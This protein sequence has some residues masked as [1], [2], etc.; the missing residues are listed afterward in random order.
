[1]FFYITIIK[2]QQTSR[3]KTIIKLIQ[4]ICVVP[5]VGRSG[6]HTAGSSHW[7]E[8]ALHTPTHRSLSK[9][10]SFTSVYLLDDTHI[11]MHECMTACLPKETIDAICGQTLSSFY[12]CTNVYKQTHTRAHTN[13]CSTLT[14]SYIQAC[15]HWHS[16][17]KLCNI[18]QSIVLEYIEINDAFSLS[19]VMK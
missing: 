7:L 6:L 14:Y 4:N 2:T 11:H 17:R 9:K 18:V 15:T 8:L 1:M 3:S 19:A 10:S 5:G 16:A 12:P 13:V